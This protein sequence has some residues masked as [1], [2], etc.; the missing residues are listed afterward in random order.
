MDDGI[1]WQAAQELAPEHHAAHTMQDTWE[2][3]I[4]DWLDKPY[5][6]G[7]RIKEFRN[8]H[9]D[10]LKNGE[11]PFTTQEVLVDAIELLIAHINRGHE[12]RAGR[13]VMALGYRQER[14]MVG[15]SRAR[16]WVR[17]SS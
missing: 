15:G 17:A 7:G 9:P 11:R 14:K 4:R 13:V 3:A 10:G 12:M 5:T 1:A 8:P 2:D 16:Y 6:V